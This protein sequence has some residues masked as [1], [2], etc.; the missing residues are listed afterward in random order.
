MLQVRTLFAASTGWA[1]ASV[2]IA[3]PAAAALLS[4]AGVNDMHVGVVN[5]AHSYDGDTVV[6]N[7]NCTSGFARGAKVKAA[8]YCDSGSGSCAATAST[9]VHIPGDGS[10]DASLSIPPH[11]KGDLYYYA[12]N[13]SASDQGTCAVSIDSETAGN[14]AT[15]TLDFNYYTNDIPGSPFTVSLTD[16]SPGWVPT[17]QAGRGAPCPGTGV[18]QSGPTAQPIF[19]NNRPTF[20]RNVICNE[21]FIVSLVSG[22]LTY[23][24]ND[25]AVLT[26]SNNPGGIQQA[27]QE[28]LVNQ[29]ASAAKGLEA[30]SSGTPPKS[31]DRVRMANRI[32]KGRRWMVIADPN[33]GTLAGIV[34]DEYGEDPPEIISCEALGRD[35]HPDRREE[36][37]DYACDFR[38]VGEDDSEPSER[39]VTLPGSVTHAPLMV[40]DGGGSSAARRAPTT[41]VLALRKATR[42]LA[43]LGTVHEADGG[44][45]KIWYAGKAGGHLTLV[46]SEAAESVGILTHHPA[47]LSPSFVSC[48]RRSRDVRESRYACR[49]AASCKR[50]PCSEESWSAPIEV[51]FPNALFKSRPCAPGTGGEAVREKLRLVKL[52]DKDGSARLRFNAQIEFDV[53]L[54]P[55]PDEDGF[56]FLVEDADGDTVVDLDLPGNGAQQKRRG[57]GWKVSK[58]GRR[59]EYRSGK[60]IGGMMVPRVRIEQDKKNAELWNVEVRGNKGIFDGDDP[61]LPLSVS[62]SLAPSNPPGEACFTTGDSEDDDENRCWQSEGGGSIT[63]KSRDR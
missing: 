48:Q 54:S 53:Q 33:Q 37:T 28:A 30:N 38:R 10:S 63:C 15:F 34:T 59:F 1:I 44:D 61:A 39:T 23:P 6:L 51:E 11:Q 22:G 57:D 50:S 17:D 25:G 36:M 49:V 60:L 26:L 12:K 3:L 46:Q 13:H 27:W 29:P 7:L 58:R 20:P 62:A 5:Y 55:R 47:S 16:L 9:V 32:H 56:R 35:G 4:S 40:V 41:G 24:V 18:G 42:V 19:T 21:D 2:L 14:L 31:F 8:T 45:L 52:G 43:K